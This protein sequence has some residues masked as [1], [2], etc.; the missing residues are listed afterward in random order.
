[1]KNLTNHMGIPLLDEFKSVS[2]VFDILA[3]VSNWNEI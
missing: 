3:P 2:T 1:M